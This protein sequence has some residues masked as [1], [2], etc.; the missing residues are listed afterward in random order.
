MKKFYFIGFMGLTLL[1]TGF[2]L[3]SLKSSSGNHPKNTH[4]IL[5]DEPAVYA[6]EGAESTG[7]QEEII[8]EERLVEILPEKQQLIGVKIAEVSVKPLEKTIR[9]VGR[10]EYDEGKLTTVNIKVEGYI[11]HLYADYSGIHVKKG[12]PLADIYSPELVSTQ[13]EFINLLKWRHE[14]AH[15]FQRNIEFEWGDRYGTT[16][17]LLTFDIEALLLVAKQKLELWEIPDNQIKELEEGGKPQRIL[18]IYSPSDGYVFQK[19]VFKGTRVSPGDKIFDIVDLSTVWVIADIYEYELPVIKVGQEAKITLSYYPEKEF[20]TK[21]D[22][23]YPDLSGKTRTAKARFT[24]KNPGMLL[25]PNMFT[26]VELTVDL[27]DRLSIPIDAVIDTGTRQIVYVDKGDG[28]FE[29]RE[30]RLGIRGDDGM[31]EV[32]KG[33]KSKEKIAS[34]ATFLIDSEAKLMGIVY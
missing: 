16:G 27:G 2:L 15:R 7:E 20:I 24:I 18:T 28:Y 26:N 32:L 34:S 12:A 17:R 4:G 31:V 8:E 6:Q 29:P 30:V 14:M 10:V 11:E 13:L 3:Y 19:P 33:L 25:K 9:T 22:F 5:Q 1:L 21:I 23:I